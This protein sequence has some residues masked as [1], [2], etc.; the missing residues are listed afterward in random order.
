[1]INSTDSTDST[2]FTDFF[3]LESL[4]IVFSDNSNAKNATIYGNGNNQVKVTVTAKVKKKKDNV[5][6]YYTIDELKNHISLIDYTSAEQIP[7]DSDNGWSA[8][9]CDKGYV[10]AI[11]PTTMT[12]DS[13]VTESELQDGPEYLL[14]MYLSS[15]TLSDGKDVA[16]NI[17]IKGVGDFNT[18][19]TGTDT[20]NG[21]NGEKGSVFKSPQM[22]HVQA[23]RKIDYTSNENL[24]FSGFIQSSYDFENIVTDMELLK[25]WNHEAFN[26]DSSRFTAQI[27]PAEANFKFKKMVVTSSTNATAGFSIYGGACD[28]VYGVGQGVYDTNFIFVNK[29]K[30]GLNPDQNINTKDDYWGDTYSYHIGPNDGRHKWEE[31]LPE[32]II[33]IRYCSHRINRGG[34]YQSGWSDANDKITID[35]ADDYG[36]ESVISITWSDLRENFPHLDVN[37]IKI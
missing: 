35:V 2:D 11:F 8:S 36:N 5:E 26:G 9:L 4:K 10:N 6:S 16:V 30:Y 13:G 27:S 29:E 28:G 12:E 32:G 19:E 1:M 22:V 24:K 14:Y 20:K 37:G 7:S 33:T 21:P 18:T 17:N 34:L 25:N 3:K 23:L 15:K 31:H